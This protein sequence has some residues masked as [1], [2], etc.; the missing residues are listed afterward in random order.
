MSKSYNPFAAGNSGMQTKTGR[1]ANPGISNNNSIINK[2]KHSKL[3]IFSLFVVLM[4]LTKSYANTY[5]ITNCLSCELQVTLYFVP[6]CACPSATFNVLP[7]CTSYPFGDSFC[8]CNI[9]YVTVCDLATPQNCASC[10]FYPGTNPA[11]TSTP[12]LCGT[13]TSFTVT[14]GST[15]VYIS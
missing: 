13:V 14:V 8:S 12:Y 7:G 2:M 10:T 9:S 15:S 3:V 6:P 1:Q 5:D 11:C 4:S